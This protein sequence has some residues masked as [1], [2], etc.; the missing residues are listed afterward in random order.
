M[1]CLRSFVESCKK[2]YLVHCFA[3]EGCSTNGKNDDNDLFL[4]QEEIELSE[5][6]CYL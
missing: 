5:P 4:F 1:T 2:Y 6:W 3:Y